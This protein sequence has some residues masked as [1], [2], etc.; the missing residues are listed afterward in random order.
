MENYKDITI[1]VVE[2]GYIVT[3]P[4]GKCIFYT[5][6]ELREWLKNNLAPTG[7]V[8]RF[9][10]ALD[11]ESSPKYNIGTDFTSGYITNTDI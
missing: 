4:D 7:E 6:E 10:D 5:S 11:N 9:S 2:N 3:T 8:E 1:E